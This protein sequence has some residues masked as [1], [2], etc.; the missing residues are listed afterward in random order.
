MAWVAI[1][2]LHRMFEEKRKEPAAVF[3]EKNQNLVLLFRLQKGEI[4]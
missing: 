2:A 1:T 3:I 4:F